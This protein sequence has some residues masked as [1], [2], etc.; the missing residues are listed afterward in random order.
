MNGSVPDSPTKQMTKE[1]LEEINAATAITSI[2]DVLD[3]DEPEE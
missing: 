2:S 3:D 1:Q